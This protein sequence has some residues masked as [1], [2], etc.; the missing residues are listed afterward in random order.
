[1]AA[2][3]A[4]LQ[5]VSASVTLGNGEQLQTVVDASF[6]IE[7]GQSYAIVGKSGSGKTSLVSIIGL[8]NEKFSGHY[9]YNG[10]DVSRLKDK[11]RSRLRA[12]SIG[13]VFQNYS[14]I[15]HLSVVEN[16][17][18]ALQY[19]GV[20]LRSD[21][22]KRRTQQV[23]AAVG[24]AERGHEYPNRLSGGEQQRVAIARALVVKPELLIC[25]EPTGALDA[26]TSASIMALL[27]QLVSEQSVSL[28]LV[29]HDMDIAKLCGTIHEIEKGVVGNAQNAN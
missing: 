16:I 5:K 24:L 6:D 20:P 28:V 22:A 17:N 15:Q 1:M 10:A 27:L 2:V 9:F 19:G 11:E 7:R 13:F 4:S 23:L 29:T 26:D 3:L 14:L 8:L 21:F 25:D 18:L 12:K